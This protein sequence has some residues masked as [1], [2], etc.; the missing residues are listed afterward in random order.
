MRVAWGKLS[1][2]LSVPWSRLRKPSRH[3]WIAPLMELLARIA[4]SGSRF[5]L[6]APQSGRHAGRDK[7][8]N[9]T[10][11][12]DTFVAL[13]A[14]SAWAL[15]GLSFLPLAEGWRIVLTVVM[16]LLCLDLISYT[17]C[18]AIFDPALP[19]R[20][21]VVRRHENR[22]A[23]AE[24]TIVLALLNYFEVGVLFGG[25]YALWR[26]E[27]ISPVVSHLGVRGPTQWDALYLSFVTQ[28]TIGYGDVTPANAGRVL[29]AVQCMIVL[30]LIA[31][32]L[33]R[34]VSVLPKTTAQNP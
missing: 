6:S 26:D 27:V 20:K 4:C 23:S 8:A 10:R 34:F 31:L 29:V 13:R 9:Q 21:R 33:G 5:L 25:I 14:L 32:L 30:L 12:V 28:L 19:P 11:R 16:A 18:V 2:E 1:F 15:F 24:R 7:R 17:T 3:G 22:L